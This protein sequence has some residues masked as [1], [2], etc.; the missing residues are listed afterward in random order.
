MNNILKTT[1]KRILQKK[2]KEKAEF[3]Y[4]LITE[5]KYFTDYIKAKNSYTNKYT[6]ALQHF[7][8][9]KGLN[10]VRHHN[11]D[12]NQHLKK[13]SPKEV[14]VCCNYIDDKLRKL[15]F[16]KEFKRFITRIYLSKLDVYR[17]PDLDFKL[18]LS[19]ADIQAIYNR[20]LRNRRK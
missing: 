12:L 6:V 7:I 10:E 9:Y 14:I 16:S 11:Y 13:M 15:E 17:I 3:I 18:V 4:E 1:V 19:H 8:N 5:P 2:I 20:L